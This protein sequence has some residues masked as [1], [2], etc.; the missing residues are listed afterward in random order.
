MLVG[1]VNLVNIKINLTTEAD[2]GLVKIVPQVN[3]MVILADHV[4][5]VRQENTMIT[6]DNNN[7]KSVMKA[8]TIVKLDK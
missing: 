4:L 8:N 3:T 1:Y 6:L 7:A 2:P 5:N